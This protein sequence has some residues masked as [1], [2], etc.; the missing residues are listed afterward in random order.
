LFC[1]AEISR[2]AIHAACKRVRRIASPIAAF[3]LWRFPLEQPRLSRLLTDALALKRLKLDLGSCTFRTPR[4][5]AST[6][7]RKTRAP[8]AKIRVPHR[9]AHPPNGFYHELR[10]TRTATTLLKRSS[11][12]AFRRLMASTPRLIVDSPKT[13]SAS[14]A[15]A[16]S[17]EIPPNRFRRSVQILE[18]MPNRVIFAKVWII[19]NSD[20]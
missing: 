13:R 12:Q 6:P 20:K 7:H 1:H 4:P 17:L 8:P 3:P 10:Q 14:R 9:K 2:A 5:A 11:G 16:Q 15:F 19:C 18:I